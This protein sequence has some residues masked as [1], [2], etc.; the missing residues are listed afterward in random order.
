MTGAAVRASRMAGSPG[1]CGGCPDGINYGKE[2]GNGDLYTEKRHPKPRRGG[3][4]KE[5]EERLLGM[6]RTLDARVSGNTEGIDGLNRLAQEIR[7]AAAG[8][9]NTAD[10][11]RNAAAGAQ[12]T[13][14]AALP[15]NYVTDTKS[16][17]D[18][19]RALSAKEN[20]A[21]INDSLRQNIVNLW[22]KV[23]TYAP[24]TP[25][26][27]WNGEVI[28]T[29]WGIQQCHTLGQLLFFHKN[30]S[31]NKNYKANTYYKIGTFGNYRPK[32]DTALLMHTLQDNAWGDYV[33]H[34]V[35]RTNGEVWFAPSA[36]CWTMA[37][38][39]VGMWVF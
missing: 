30:L 1:R 27:T 21:G 9:Q 18:N 23:N 36:D 13:A 33:F 16:V 7:T 12:N 5:L 20:N 32:A 10:S 4:A 31:C 11:A 29:D 14:N 24:V 28:R 22:A 38:D 35:I 2:A 25:A 19:S 15:K 37:M 39:L 34:A 26:I 8:A 3:G 6:V 17:T